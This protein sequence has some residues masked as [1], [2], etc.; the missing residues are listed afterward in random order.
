M[1]MHFLQ[2]GRAPVFLIQEIDFIGGTKLYSNF[3]ILVRRIKI[4]P[5]NNFLSPKIYSKI[6]IPPSFSNYITLSLIILF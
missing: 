6:I 2:F 1:R 5:G 4:K 3:S